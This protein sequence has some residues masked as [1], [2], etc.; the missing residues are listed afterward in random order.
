MAFRPVKAVPIDQLEVL[1]MEQVLIQ[2][3]V[4]LIVEK[5]EELRATSDF[6]KTGTVAA[7]SDKI[8][9]VCIPLR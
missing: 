5:F 2:L 4:F 8:L 3:A 1:I 6:L 9:N 7:G